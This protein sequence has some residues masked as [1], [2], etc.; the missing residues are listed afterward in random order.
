VVVA[1]ICNS[2]LI[3]R[4]IC[5]HSDLSFQFQ[6]IFFFCFFPLFFFFFGSFKNHSLKYIAV[7]RLKKLMHIPYKDKVL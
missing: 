4:I 5:S 2:N 6:L 1:I 3:E 7:V